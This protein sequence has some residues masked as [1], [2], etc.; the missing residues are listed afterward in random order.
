MARPILVSYSLGQEKEGPEILLIGAS[1]CLWM[2]A[3][4][5]GSNFETETGLGKQL[6]IFGNFLKLASNAEI[7]LH[8]LEKN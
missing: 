5:K 2:W 6:A 3:G 1:F 7:E 4:D 8:I